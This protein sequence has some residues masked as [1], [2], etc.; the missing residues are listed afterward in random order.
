VRLRSKRCFA[1]CRQNGSGVIIS[2]E[3]VERRRLGP[4]L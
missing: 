2:R 1:L 4:H 3:S